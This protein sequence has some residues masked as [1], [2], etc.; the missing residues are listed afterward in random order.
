LY[1]ALRKRINPASERTRL[2]INLPNAF[3]GHQID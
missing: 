3:P 2:E 1:F